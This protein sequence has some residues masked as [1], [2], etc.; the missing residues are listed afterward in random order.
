V[1]TFCESAVKHLVGFVVLA[2]DHLELLACLRHWFDT[3]DAF[4]NANASLQGW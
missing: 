3:D 1:R 4:R 2:L